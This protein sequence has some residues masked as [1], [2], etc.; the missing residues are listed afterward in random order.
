MGDILVAYLEGADSGRANK[1]FAASQS[2]FDLWFKQEAKTITGVDF[3]E[4]LP[5]GSTEVLLEMPGTAEKKSLGLALPVLQGKTEDFRRWARE[6]SGPRLAEFNDFLRRAGITKANVYLQHTPMG[7]FGVQYSEGS[8]PPG[9][10]QF[11]AKSNAPFE[12]WAREQL[13]A[14]HGVDFSQRN[15][16][17]ARA[18]L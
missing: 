14:I 11:F 16:W 17:P 6:Q 3:G 15:A 13:A 7:D 4:P 1:Q 12:T 18:C 10:Y 9:A 8:D 2:A 5:A